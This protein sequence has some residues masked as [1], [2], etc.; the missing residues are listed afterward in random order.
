[1]KKELVNINK[2][3]NVKPKKLKKSK[4]SKKYMSRNTQDT[5]QQKPIETTL[6]NLKYELPEI[7][8][9]GKYL[10]KYDNFMKKEKRLFKGFIKNN[11]YEYQFKLKQY[12]SVV[13]LNRTKQNIGTCW[14]NCFLNTIIFGKNFRG[15]MIQS[16]LKH[17]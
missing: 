17:I 5:E 6:F 16:L 1:M 14:M 15:K 13:G 3:F 7:K 12:L 9:D 11:F 8:L 10:T 2:N 4:K